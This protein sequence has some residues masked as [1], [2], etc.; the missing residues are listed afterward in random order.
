M[1]ISTQTNTN[2]LI[3]SM[4]ITNHGYTIKHLWKKKPN[5]SV[6][7]AIIANNIQYSTIQLN[8]MKIRQGV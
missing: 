7:I 8:G 5:T 1:S 6:K 2:H 3:Q 4:I